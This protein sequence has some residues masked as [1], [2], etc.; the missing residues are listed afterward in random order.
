[1]SDDKR[2][3]QESPVRSYTGGAGRWGIASESDSIK[4]REYCRWECWFP[5]CSTALG[6]FHSQA[7]VA[8]IVVHVAAVAAGQRRNVQSVPFPRLAIPLPRSPST[9]PSPF[10]ALQYPSLD[11][12]QPLL[13]LFP[14][15]NTPL[16]I[17]FSLQYTSLDLLQPF[18]LGRSQRTVAAILGKQY[19]SKAS[20]Q[21]IVSSKKPQVGNCKWFWHY[22]S[23]LSLLLSLHTDSSLPWHSPSGYS[24][25]A[26]HHAPPPP[27]LSSYQPPPQP[28]PCKHLAYLPQC[29]L[30][31]QHPSQYSTPTTQIFGHHAV[32]HPTRDRS[33]NAQDLNSLWYCTALHA[34]WTA[35]SI[36]AFDKERK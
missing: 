12:L 16:S 31:K 20:A 28:T 33:V 6:A 15:C 4:D 36:S 19:I 18:L 22:N 30:C 23:S 32:K 11:L 1:M 26:L 9:P 2:R 24:P 8:C 27:L 25:S 29:L 34:C 10:L 7:P 17:S 35:V 13:L 14:S 5:F 21:E 3:N